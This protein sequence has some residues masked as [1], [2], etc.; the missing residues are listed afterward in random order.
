MAEK[1]ATCG[2]KRIGNGSPQSVAYSLL[3]YRFFV[4]LQGECHDSSI[5]WGDTPAAWTT[6]DDLHA[7]RRL[8]GLST[9]CFYHQS[10]ILEKR[11]RFLRLCNSAAQFNAVGHPS[12]SRASSM[13]LTSIQSS[14][15][16]LHR[17][18]PPA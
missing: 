14:P 5:R 15:Q 10:I 8:P 18:Q 16:E 11:T 2:S 17:L 4:C 12:T 7:V 13:P 6:C 1:P 3:E 9:T